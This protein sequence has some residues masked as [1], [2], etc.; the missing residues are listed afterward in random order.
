MGLSELASS[1]SRA[2]QRGHL[3]FGARKQPLDIGKVRYDYLNK[4]H[5]G[6]NYGGSVAVCKN[7]I[8]YGRNQYADYGYQEYI[9]TIRLARMPSTSR[10]IPNTGLS[11]ISTPHIAATPFPPL[12]SI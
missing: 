12:K 9:L 4:S 11:T 5:P 8:A 6:E 10:I 2:V 7:G 1:A 3:A